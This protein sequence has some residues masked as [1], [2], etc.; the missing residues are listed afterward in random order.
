MRGDDTEGQRFGVHWAVFLPTVAIAVLYTI[1][2]F[3]FTDIRGTSGGVSRAALLVLAVGVPLLLV[4][5]GLRYVNGCIELGRDHMVVHPGWPVRREAQISFKDIARLTVKRGLI[6]RIFD[7]G[8]LV[9]TDNNG[10]H[11]VMPD[12]AAPDRVEQALFA[13]V[14]PPATCVNASPA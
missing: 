7:V 10:D 12:L 1:L 8:T 13:L 2:W 11:T 3:W 9:V 6:G 5:A 4:H 14:E